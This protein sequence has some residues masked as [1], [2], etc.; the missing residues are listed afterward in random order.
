MLWVPQVLEYEALTG[1]E[2]RLRATATENQVSW[3]RNLAVI[4]VAQFFSIMAFSFSLPILP[5]FVRDLGVADA[6]RAAFWSGVAIGMMGLGS[7]LT[8]PVWGVLGDRYGRKPN[9]LRAL[10][11]TSGMLVVTG[12]SANIYQLVVFRFITGL[13]SGIWPTAMALVA[14]QTPRE[15][16]GFS[17]GL[18]LMAIF[19]GVTLG[20]LV[21]GFLS[22][23]FGFRNSFFIGGAIGGLAATAVLLFVREEFQRPGETRSVSIPGIA[24]DFVSMITAKEMSTVLIVMF[25]VNI[26]PVMTYPLLPLFIQ[27]ISSSLSAAGVAGVAFALMGASS[28]VASFVIG[29]LST[30]VSLRK[31]L[32]VAPLLAGPLFAPMY[33]AQSIFHV[34][35]LFV[36]LGFFSG[37]MITTANA[38][39]GVMMPRERQ[40]RGFGAVQSVNSMALG[41]GPLLGGVLAVLVGF[42]PV[43]LVSAAGFLLVAL[44]VWR[45]VPVQGVSAKAE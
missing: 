30:Q 3:K 32:I 35:I 40:S 9:M 38:Y 31:I 22:N 1:R 26:T 23:A 10:Y 17:M 44:V 28:A 45:L 29:R 20:P 36:V 11:C 5:L 8:G 27:E 24:R 2:G 34:Y 18:L 37:G 15:R 41:L 39:I 16:M 13:V 7:F 14:S 12:L 25:M 33:L 42:R 43:F 19:S 6:G 4:W 21:G